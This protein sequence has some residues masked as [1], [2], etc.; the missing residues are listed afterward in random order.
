MRVDMVL[1]VIL[2]TA[3]AGAH[4]PHKYAEITYHIALY[5]ILKL[6]SV[7]VM[8]PQPLRSGCGPAIRHDQPSHIHCETL[9]LRVMERGT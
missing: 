7:R 3:A 6:T 9:W 8:G 2:L 1:N 5:S 4:D